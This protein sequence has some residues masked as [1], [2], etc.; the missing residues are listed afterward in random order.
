MNNQLQEK[1]SFQ[2]PELP[3]TERDLATSVPDGTGAH[4]KFGWRGKSRDIYEICQS[5][6]VKHD[7]LLMVATD[8]VSA[9]DVVL[10]DLIPGKGKILTAISK[11]WF[12]LCK[13]I[14]PNHLIDRRPEEVLTR[15]EATADMCQRSLLVR[16]LQP[17]AF[18]AIVRGYLCGSG[19]RDYQ[20]NRTVSGV[21]LPPGLSHCARLPE[22]IFTPSTKAPHGAHDMPV[23][24]QDMAASISLERATEV[25]E[26]SLAIYR[27]CSDYARARGLIIADTKFE[28]AY[29]DSGKLVL[30]DELVTPDSSRFWLQDSWH[31]K[32]PPPSLDKQLIRDHLESVGWNKTPPAPALPESLLAQVAEAYQKIERML[33][34]RTGC[35]A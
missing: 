11:F 27:R 19:W 25:R 10:P 20:L 31:K 9:F 26:K 23:G 16:R 21:V 12:S 8:R 17:L 6:D 24:F 28:F 33:L 7:E 32:L 15:E 30:I 14:V 3:P 5:G 4:I 22:P 1:S 18:E 35:E 2:T 34:P 13:D 29:D